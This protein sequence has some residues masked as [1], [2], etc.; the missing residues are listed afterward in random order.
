MK[1][2][3]LIIFYAVALIT[4]RPL[5]SQVELVADP[6]D[7]EFTH[8]SNP[9]SFVNLQG[10]IYFGAED[11]H[12]RGFWKSDGTVD[13]TVLV[14]RKVYPMYAIAYKDSILMAG[15]G[16]HGN[17]VN[18]LWI[19][20]GTEEG[21]ELLLEFD[22][23]TEP[24]F[25]LVGKKV[26]FCL[27]DGDVE[28]WVTEGTAESTRKVS[29][30]GGTP[31]F[32]NSM[33]AAFGNL[34]FSA[35][36]E[37]HGTIA[38]KSDGSAEGTKPLM[39]DMTVLGNPYGFCELDDS[40]YFISGHFMDAALYAAAGTGWEARKVTGFPENLTPLDHMS[41]SLKQMVEHNDTLY[42]GIR[43]NLTFKDDIF[44]YSGGDTVVP[45][46][47]SGT[48]SFDYPVRF[49]QLNHV[50]MLGLARNNPRSPLEFRL[51]RLNGPVPGVIDS[52]ME[53]S[54]S[55][56]DNNFQEC[57]SVLYFSYNNYIRKTDGTPGS[58]IHVNHQF[59]RPDHHR[60]RTF[61]MAG[62]R[63]FFAGF[64]ESAGTELWKQQLP[65]G[66]ANILKDINQ[67]RGYSGMEIVY[68]DRQKLIFTATT[69]VAGNELWS[70]HHDGTAAALV[71]DI[72]PGPDY[73]N[74][75]NF[76]RYGD[77][78]YFSADNGHRQVVSG[79]NMA[80]GFW[81][82]DGTAAGTEKVLDL[83][84][85]YNPP[86]QWNYR[87]S[88]M[89]ELNGEILLGGTWPDEDPNL[90]DVELFATDGSAEGTRLVKN[91]NEAASGMNGYSHPFALTKSGEQVF[92]GATTPEK[93]TE[94]WVTDGTSGNTR[95]VMD[96]NAAG[97]G[98][99][100][101]SNIR[102]HNLTSFGNR[103]LFTP[104]D[105]DYG[106][107]L[108][109]SDGTEEGTLRLTDLPYDGYP[110]FYG[111]TVLEGQAVFWV[112]RMSAD[113]SITMWITDGTPEGTQLLRAA[114][115]PSTWLT[116]KEGP[117]G[118]F[119][120]ELYFTGTDGIH[121]L[122]LWKTDGTEAGTRMVKDLY[123]GP[124]HGN[125]EGF[126]ISGDRFYFF[127]G[128]PGQETHL[129]SSDGTG[130]GTIQEEDWDAFGL[131]YANAS[132]LY[133]GYL[134]FTASDLEN[135]E[136]LYRIPTGTTGVEK[137]QHSSFSLFPNPAR[138]R[139][140][141]KMEGMKPGILTVWSL[142]GRILIREE[143]NS[144]QKVINISSLEGGVYL[145]CYRSGEKIH[146]S[147]LVKVD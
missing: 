54:Y 25:T 83:L 79:V 47:P 142:D 62:N 9:A 114:G 89:V 91:I 140:R 74:P 134:Y 6:D 147:K 127:A 43:N 60:R 17:P 137:E 92:F 99:S 130:P 90:M 71:K 14:T 51:L 38:W 80:S 125:P 110:A 57:D 84:T 36:H 18:G 81:R 108:W 42:F 101:G 10:S 82:T 104:A 31:L 37:S 144:R 105:N 28:L 29:G 112:E 19:S 115:E 88:E 78:L 27:R 143:I 136:A 3:S 58:I 39:D 129:W 122:E 73:A 53:A 131:R 76:L 120:G 21:T 64:N 63:I 113:S 49:Y 69:D 103:V 96:I 133:A 61:H 59:L 12:G 56:S 111:F 132:T 139:I 50:V 13:G 44:C 46:Y 109:V 121:G 118:V 67:T 40:L 30:T 33:T 8:S 135:G 34:Y 65:E 32:P 93:G 15:H 119:G 87:G 126:V 20:D 16:Y 86:S 97:N 26:F 66:Q 22:G 70:V 106:R 146:T 23:Y 75:R 68:G 55:W 102:D 4:I 5:Y 138:D 128:G 117:L 98:S 124:A 52:I 72:A 94:L 45:V 41:E 2:S 123:E 35:D 77:A 1:S 107:E 100:L 116:W 11:F 7:S 95:M 85:G 48:S 141:L 24:Q 145:V